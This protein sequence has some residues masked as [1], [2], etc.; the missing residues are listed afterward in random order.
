MPGTLRR[1]MPR[2]RGAQR[3]YAAKNYN[4]DSCAHKRGTTIIPKTI[5]PLRGTGSRPKAFSPEA[6]YIDSSFLHIA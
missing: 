3:G 6:R 1:E 5:D 4:F 2:L